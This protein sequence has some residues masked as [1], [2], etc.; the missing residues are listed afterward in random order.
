MTSIAL[1]LSSLIVQAAVAQLN[2]ELN[3]GSFHKLLVE[4]RH[5][6]FLINKKDTWV[7]RSLDLY[8]EWEEV[9]VD[10]ISEYISEGDVVVDV[11]ANIGAYTVP[12]SKMVGD[13]GRVVSFEPQRIIS[14][15]LT[16]NVALNE[17]T[18]VGV[19]NSGVGNDSYPLE[20]PDVLYVSEANFGS[21]S[22]VENWKSKGASTSLVPQVLID[23]VFAEQC[24]AFI[25]I[26][27]EGMELQV[28]E[29]SERTMKKCIPVLFV[30][31]NCKLG[32]KEL[33]EFVS[34]L[35]YICHWSIHSYY[36]E[37]NFKE[38]KENIFPQNANSINMLCYSRHDQK[39]TQ[40]ASKSLPSITR[41][42]GIGGRYMLHEYNLIYTGK[43][44]VLS[45]MGTLESCVR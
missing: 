32:S 17:L 14:Q 21:I 18:N 42:D 31:N 7:G 22:L 5:G 28:L 4:C 36:S 27:V 43:E 41:I 23:D 12:M 20:V 24:P 13:S 8:G 6:T 34:R 16:A 40:T 15:L 25:K 19:F 38:N 44:G 3:V 1:L 10:Q 29:G 30:E 45:Q 26:D 35:D 39:S 37:A 33:I 9:V 2:V 11:G